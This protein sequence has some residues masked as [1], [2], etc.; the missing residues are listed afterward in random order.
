MKRNIGIMII[1]IMLLFSL[2]MPIGNVYAASLSD[3]I[4]LQ[5]TET[6]TESQIDINV[7]LVTNTG[8]SSMTLEL[9]YDKEVFEYQGYE[10]GTALSE[11][12]LMSTDLSRNKDLPVKFNWFNQNVEND[13]STGNILKLHFNLKSNIASGDYKIGFKYNNG[14]I[15]YVENKNPASKS[16]IISQAVISVSHNKITKTEIV[17]EAN[18]VDSPSNTWIVVVAVAAFV[19]V[20]TVATIITIKAIRRKRKNKNWVKI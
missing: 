20:A 5:L 7:K 12:D 1:T 17:E 18:D 13:F 10:K 19:G 4:I 11:L 3:S 9:V 16:A 14:D 6:H 8:L 15:V 2:F